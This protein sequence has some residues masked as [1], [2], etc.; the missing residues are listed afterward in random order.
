MKP[1]SVRSNSSIHRAPNFRSYQWRPAPLQTRFP[2][3]HQNLN[4]QRTSAK[5]LVIFSLQLPVFCLTDVYWDMCEL[6]ERRSRPS[7]KELR[8]FSSPLGPFSCHTY[9]TRRCNSFACPPTKTPGV[10]YPFPQTGTPLTF[11][12]APLFHSL[13]LRLPCL[14]ASA[15]VRSSRLRD[16]GSKRGRPVL[17]SHAQRKIQEEFS[18]LPPRPPLNQPLKSAPPSC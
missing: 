2:G 12:N 13:S 17:P 9:R 5:S 14:S 7:P 6:I 3:N 1:G 11:Y 4:A 8:P 18:W 10:R 16:R 15:G